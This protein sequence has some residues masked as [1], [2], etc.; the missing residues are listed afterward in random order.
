M[1]ENFSKGKR[2]GLVKRLTFTQM[3]LM[4]EL[5]RIIQKMA[6]VILTRSQKYISDNSKMARKTGMAI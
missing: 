6:K 2:M 3:S 4:M 1:T 5:R